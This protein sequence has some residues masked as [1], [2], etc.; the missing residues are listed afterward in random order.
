VIGIRCLFI[1]RFISHILT[2]ATKFAE[3]P[4]ATS[5][6]SALNGVRSCVAGVVSAQDNTKADV[7]EL[8]VRLAEEKD[9]RENTE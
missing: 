7:I 8:S 4:N 1:C 6:E 5:C 3:S 9:G 2:Q